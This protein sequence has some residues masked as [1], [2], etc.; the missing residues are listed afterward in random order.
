M[1]QKANYET[2]AIKLSKAI[3]IAIKAFKKFPPYM[4]TEENL[5]DVEKCHIEWKNSALNPSPEYKKI[6]SLKYK[7]ESVFTI[8]NEGSGEFVEYFWK[9]IKN[10]NLDYVREDKLNKILKR[11]KIKS[12]IEYD[13]ITDIIIVAEQEDRITKE[14]SKLLNEMI[15]VFEIKQ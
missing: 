2:E 14:E 8:F 3:D 9:E 6:S 1:K 7:I 5:S 4:W 12:R 10:Q 15:G 11:G 13:Y